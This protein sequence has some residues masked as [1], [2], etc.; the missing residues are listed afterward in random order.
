MLG[1]A[2]ST[3]CPFQAGV[4]R[5]NLKVSGGVN[6]TYGLWMVVKPWTLPAD[7]VGRP[8]ASDIPRSDDG[9]KAISLV[10]KHGL[11]T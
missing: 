4:S 11:H 3:N 5:K 2:H 8:K 9:E 7:Q 1:G 6:H 10:V